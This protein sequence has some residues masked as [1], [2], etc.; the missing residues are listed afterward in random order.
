MEVSSLREPLNTSEDNSEIQEFDLQISYSS[1]VY[2]ILTLQYLFMFY[3]CGVLISMPLVVEYIQQS[4]VTV[5]I[6]VFQNFLIVSF[7]FFSKE[8]ARIF[9][10]NYLLLILY[11][12]NITFLAAAVCTYFT[13]I[14]YSGLLAFLAVTL[15]LTIY[16][17]FSVFSEYY[18]STG[19]KLI[20]IWGILLMTI[21]L[22]V[23]GFGDYYESFYIPF[24]ALFYGI[25]LIIDTHVIQPSGTY[26]LTSDDV[27]IGVLRTHIDFLYFLCKLI[28]CQYCR[29]NEA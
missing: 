3:V 16:T 1:R 21:F 8:Y 15:A 5:G 4:Y 18:L 17:R 2:G 22:V 19:I 24:I 25:W 11:T 27:T 6:C 26:F 7:A 20:V 10:T 9:P 29:S 13:E 23:R 28:S 12:F 14:L